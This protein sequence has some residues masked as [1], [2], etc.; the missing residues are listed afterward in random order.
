ML[1]GPEVT[2][3]LPPSLP[4]QFDGHKMHVAEVDTAKPHPGAKEVAEE[5]VQARE[6]LAALAAE[7][8]GGVGSLFEGDDGY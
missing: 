7:A 6:E 4:Q 2:D 1:A 8:A 3:S 5:R